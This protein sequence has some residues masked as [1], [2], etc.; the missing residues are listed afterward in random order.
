MKLWIILFIRV[1]KHN[2]FVRHLPYV[3]PESCT[4]RKN[5]F[6][7][8]SSRLCSAE[9]SIW[10][11][12]SLWDDHHY[13]PLLFNLRII[14]DVKYIHWKKIGLDGKFP[15][16]R[17]L[18]GTWTGWLKC[19]DFAKGDVWFQRK[20][21]ITFRSWWFYAEKW[22]IRLENIGTILTTCQVEKFHKSEKTVIIK[23]LISFFIFSNPY[24]FCSYIF[25]RCPSCPSY[26]VSCSTETWI[27]IFI[28]RKLIKIVLN[29]GNVNITSKSAIV[30]SSGTNERY[31]IVLN[32]VF[33]VDIWQY[34]YWDIMSISS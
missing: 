27:S 32:R 26:K 10:P 3:H 9:T 8:H 5:I 7:T 16:R 14:L 25:F 20:G 21:M 23:E 34:T 31:D 24:L 28:E 30:W 22:V 4:K 13:S 6:R 19:R 17:M 18:V 11:S 2:K 12:S 1:F 33:F 29:S 15:P